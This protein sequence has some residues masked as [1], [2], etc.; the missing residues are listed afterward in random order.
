MTELI[1]HFHLRGIKVVADAVLNHTGRDFWAF[2]DLRQKGYLSNYKDWFE[3]I[4][5][6]KKSPLGDSFSYRSWRGHYSLVKLNL[7]NYYVKEHLFN[8]VKMWA[9]QL[10]FDGIRVDSADQ[11]NISFIKELR[12]FCNTFDKEFFIIGELIHGDYKK[13]LNEMNSVTN[14]Q[15][16]HEIYK[17]FSKN[18]F[19][20]IAKSM[21]WQYGKFGL[22]KNNYLYTFPDNHDVTRIASKIKKKAK[23][24]PLYGLLFTMPGIPAVYY[25]SE[26]GIKASKGRKSDNKL[27]PFLDLNKYL[28]KKSDLKEA[29]KKFIYLRNNSEALLFGNYETIISDKNLLVFSRSTNKEKII[30]IINSSDKIFS[31]S[32]SINFNCSKAFDLLNSEMFYIKN[33]IIHIENIWSNWL[34]VLKLLL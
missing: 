23:L 18:D 19:G 17:S 10:G 9:N 13:Y 3:G 28:K 12:A 20:I 21:E 7:K 24:Y 15:N 31:I 14:Y 22:Y 6:N 4:N 33:N 34:R 32:L 1:K 8:A 11:I 16:Y 29:I 25:G 5:F 27:R 2:Y 26:F 30:V